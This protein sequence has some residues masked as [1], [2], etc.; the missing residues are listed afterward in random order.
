MKIVFLARWYPHKYDPMFGL[1]VQRHAEAAALHDKVTVVYVH[2]DENA[3]DKYERSVSVSPAAS[4]TI[5]FPEIV[6]VRCSGS[7]VTFESSIVSSGGTTYVNLL[8]GKIPALIEEFRL[9]RSVI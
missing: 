2:P 5:S 3:K 8:P 7:M 4:S 1:F 9:N 6:P